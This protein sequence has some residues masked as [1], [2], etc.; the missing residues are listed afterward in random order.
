M[1]L[2]A[3]KAPR[4]E[5]TPLTTPDKVIVRTTYGPVTNEVVEDVGH[6]RSF[7]TQLG[8]LLDELDADKAAREA[9]ADVDAAG[10]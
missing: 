4:H 10:D 6:V 8:N 5:N 9:V 1:T 3:N 7:H 2:S